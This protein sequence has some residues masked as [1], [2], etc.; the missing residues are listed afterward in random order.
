MISLGTLQD[1]ILLEII[2][3]QFDECIIYFLIFWVKVLAFCV[4]GAIFPLRAASPDAPGAL[5][6]GLLGPLGGAPR[7]GSSTQLA[8]PGGVVGGARGSQ[9]EKHKETDIES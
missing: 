2:I 4:S 7:P 1:Q 5:D 6:R 8:G 9:L 3:S